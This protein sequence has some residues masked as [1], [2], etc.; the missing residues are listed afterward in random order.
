M[1]NKFVAVSDL[2]EKKKYDAPQILIKEQLRINL[3]TG[4]LP[5]EPPPPL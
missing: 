4:V 2:Y 1:L 5:D 3:Q